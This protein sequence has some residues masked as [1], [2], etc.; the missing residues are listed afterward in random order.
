VTSF[1]AKPAFAQALLSNPAIQP[2]QRPAK[3]VLCATAAGLLSLACRHDCL[4]LATALTRLGFP[5]LMPG[6]S[7]QDADR[8]SNWISSFDRA[9]HEGATKILMYMHEAGVT[10]ND[11]EK[12]GEQ[13]DAWRWALSA[14]GISMKLV[15]E[16]ASAAW[17]EEREQAIAADLRDQVSDRDRIDSLVCREFSNVLRLSA[18]QSLIA[19]VWGN[20]VLGRDGVIVQRAAEH[21]VVTR[22]EFYDS[23]NLRLDSRAMPFG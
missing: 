12:M 11:V 9:R 1:F 20:A 10:Q 13:L 6:G 3:Q 7:I 8:R 14:Q 2:P 21:E 19:N 15:R 18:E 16:Y 17:I 4:A 5:L 23:I 22:Q